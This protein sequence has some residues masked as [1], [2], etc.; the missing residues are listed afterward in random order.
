M[1][2]ELNAVTDW[3]FLAS[4][5]VE[6]NYFQLPVAGSEDL[7]YRERVYCYELYHRWR[8]HWANGFPFSLCGE[9]D[10]AGHP[11]IRNRTKPDFLVH[12]P[13]R[14]ANLLIVEVKPGNR[15]D[16]NAIKQMVDDLAKLTAFRRDLKNADGSPGNYEAAYF[17]IYGI[18]DE[19]WQSL[20]PQL[21]QESNARENVDLQLITCVL[22][23]EAGQKARMVAW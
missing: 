2:A 1:N 8:T 18:D 3:L 15:D 21:I 19:G 9:I 5:E 4:S 12:I 22:H 16:A 14:M 11:L 7:E 6:R 17:W 20:R 23:H 10:K 13:G